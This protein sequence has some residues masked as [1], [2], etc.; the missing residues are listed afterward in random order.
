MNPVKGQSVVFGGKDFE[1]VSDVSEVEYG[2]GKGYKA[3]AKCGCEQ[4]TIYWRQVA[5]GCD[6]SSPDLVVR[7][8]VLIQ[9]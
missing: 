1:L 5:N 4:Y 6:W 3:E 2:Y 9:N 7:F 8:G